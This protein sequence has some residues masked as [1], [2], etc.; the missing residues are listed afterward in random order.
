MSTI[1]LLIVCTVTVPV[2]GDIGNVT[3]NSEPFGLK[4]MEAALEQIAN[5]ILTNIVQENIVLG[6]ITPTP[7]SLIIFRHN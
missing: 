1:V 4:I 6:V 3:L 5:I 7:I 2:S